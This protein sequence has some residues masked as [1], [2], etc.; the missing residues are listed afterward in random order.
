[1][2]EVKLMM[3]IRQYAKTEQ[4]K[5]L[6]DY[7]WD[8][9]PVVVIT[10]LPGDIAGMYSCGYIVL[11]DG[12]ESIIAPIYLHELRHRWQWQKQRFKYLLGKLYRPLIEKDAYA[13]Q[14][15]FEEWQRGIE[16][17]N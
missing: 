8:N 17:V 5:W 2:N 6:N 7:D 14:A 3:T 11:L 16:N 9:V 13:R 4:G 1:M 10:K 15:E 12:D